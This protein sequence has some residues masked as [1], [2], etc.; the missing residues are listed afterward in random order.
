M[1]IRNLP[2]LKSIMGFEGEYAVFKTKGEDSIYH[3]LINRKGEVVWYDNLWH[4]I[5]KLRDYDSIFFSMKRGVEDFVYFDA[6]QQKYIDRPQV[7]ERPKSKVEL[8]ADNSEWLVYIDENG[9]ETHQR[10]MQALSDDY[11]AYAEEPK[12]WGVKDLEGNLLIPA[13]FDSVSIGGNNQF[14]V[15]NN[16]QYGVIDIKGNWIIPYGQFDSLWFRGD[17]YLARK[18]GKAG[19]V[20][21]KGNTLIPFEYE[22]LHP[23]YTEGLDLISAKKN[24]EFFFINAKQ[25]RVDL[26]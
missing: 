5:L 24:G 3:G 11:L 1:N 13:Q 26:F 17:Y 14:V 16:E 25:E 10:S 18:G 22:Y 12:K 9:Q 6:A 4:P 19:I 21:L 23:S 8:I 20:D 15:E 7:S 2:N